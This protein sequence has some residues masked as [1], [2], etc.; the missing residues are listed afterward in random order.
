MSF[1]QL[2][3]G[4]SPKHALVMRKIETNVLPLDTPLARI[5]LESPI[6][7]AAGESLFFVNGRGPEV[8]QSCNLDP[9]T[10]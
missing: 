1:V 2:L 6:K 9:I 5:S 4:S 7:N 10:P 3:A 8:K